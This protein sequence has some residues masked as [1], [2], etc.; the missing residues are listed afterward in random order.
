MICHAAHFPLAWGAPG[1]YVLGVA[2]ETTMTDTDIL[3][4]NFTACDDND[5]VVI[6]PLTNGHLRLSVDCYAEMAR[7]DYVHMSPDA[8]RDLAALLLR[9]ADEIE[10]GS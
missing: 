7:R 9:M 5:A 2:R 4:R 1:G 3:P 10:A 6:N 8:A